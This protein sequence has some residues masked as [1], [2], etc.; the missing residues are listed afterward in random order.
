MKTITQKIVKS[1]M[2]QIKPFMKNVRTEDIDLFS[3]TILY[4][5][6]DVLTAL[7]VRTMSPEELAEE[8]LPEHE[9]FVICK[10]DGRKIQ[11]T[12]EDGIVWML[13]KLNDPK[14]DKLLTPWFRKN[15]GPIIK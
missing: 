15:I 13:L 11:F 8:L 1:I 9:I 3:K 12:T 5:A 4:S 6:A 14:Y 7:K 10:L 2:K